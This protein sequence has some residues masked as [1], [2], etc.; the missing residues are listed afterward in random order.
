MQ[1]QFSN[2][3]KNNCLI[4]SIT[5]ITTGITVQF[6]CNSKTKIT[7]L[8]SLSVYLSDANCFSVI[9]IRAHFRHQVFGRFTR[10]GVQKTQ[11]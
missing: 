11:N 3:C 1:R 2:F 6:H 8:V 4:Y 10:F 5:T 9:G 7:N